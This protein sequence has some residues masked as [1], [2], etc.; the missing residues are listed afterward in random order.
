[1]NIGIL[2]V[3]SFGEKHINV[4]KNIHD[5]NIIGFFDPNQKRS[6]EIEKKM[7]IKRYSSE[8]ELIQKCDAVDIVSNTETH[9][10]LLEMATK[11]NKHIFVE[12]PICSTQIQINKILERY[13]DYKPVIQ[14]GHIER[15]NPTITEEIM[16]LQN[17]TSI[18]SRRIGVLNDRNKN[19]PLALDLM[20]H[21]IDL[22]LNIMKSEIQDINLKKDTK[23]NFISCEISFKNNKQAHLLASRSK[24]EENERI[25]KICCKDKVIE[26]DLLK[27]IRKSNCTK[28]KLQPIKNI[29]QLEK[30]FLDFRKSIKHKTKPAIGIIDACKALNVAITIENLLQNELI[31]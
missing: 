11:Y 19:T 9:Y 27:K 12:K 21:D 5:F 2:G 30:E 14:V 15:Y 10:E 24:L 7:N 3:G 6:I 23:P 1:M 25:L 20:I 17:I 28:N 13:K 4:L 8:L 29:N 16:S 26:I 18:H 22:I 31:K